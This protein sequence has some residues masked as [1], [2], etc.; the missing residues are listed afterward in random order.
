MSGGKKAAA[1][2]GHTPGPWHVEGRQGEYDVMHWTVR[3]SYRVIAEMEPWGDGGDD[4]DARLIAAAPGMLEAL[5]EAAHYI[6]GLCFSDKPY[7][8]EQ[9]YLHA[10][11]AFAALA[12]ACPADGKGVES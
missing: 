12:A 3:T 7:L 10:K 11:R 5:R 6:D 4:A 1:D 8:E 9:R 2:V